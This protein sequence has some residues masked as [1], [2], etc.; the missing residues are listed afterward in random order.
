MMRFAAKLGCGAH[1]GDQCRYG[2]DEK[3]REVAQ[4]VSLV[5]EEGGGANSIQQKTIVM[6]QTTVVL[7]VV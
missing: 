6:R 4:K 2:R 3:V 7:F 5:A 1:I